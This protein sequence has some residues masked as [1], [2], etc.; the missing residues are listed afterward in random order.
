[1]NDVGFVCECHVNAR[2]RTKPCENVSCTVS[3]SLM[4]TVSNDSFAPGTASLYEY[5]KP[6]EGLSLK[7]PRLT[8]C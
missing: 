7:L 8:R 1:M 6:E 2:S 3:L 5:L 4:N